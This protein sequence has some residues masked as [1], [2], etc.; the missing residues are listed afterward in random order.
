MHRW[1]L[2]AIFAKCL[3]VTDFWI[4]T[5]LILGFN[6]KI[7]SCGVVKIK[8]MSS[9]IPPGHFSFV[10]RI[11][12]LSSSII[13]SLAEM[14][15]L[16]LS[17]SRPGQFKDAKSCNTVVNLNNDLDAFSSRKERKSFA[18]TQQAEDSPKESQIKGK[19]RV[20]PSPKFHWNPRNL[21]CCKC[22][23]IWSNFRSKVVKNSLCLSFLRQYLSFLSE[24]CSVS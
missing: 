17:G 10:L 24:I 15:S 11:K 22:I 13:T 14:R 6:L 9:I 18:K 23:S 21:R 4:K 8:F 5:F 20:W 19:K 7:Y 16:Q 1:K 12:S 2:S 3:G